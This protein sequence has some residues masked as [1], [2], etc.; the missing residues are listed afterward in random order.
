MAKQQKRD[1]KVKKTGFAGKNNSR[2]KRGFKIGGMIVGAAAAALLT[3][4]CSGIKNYFNDENNN[5][6]NGRNEVTPVVQPVQTPENPRERLEGLDD[7]LERYYTGN[8]NINATLVAQRGNEYIERDFTGLTLRDIQRKIHYLE[9]T[10]SF[11]NTGNPTFTEVLD[12]NIRNLTIQTNLGVV[13]I[14][15]PIYR[16]NEASSNIYLDFSKFLETVTNEQGS[17]LRTNVSEYTDENNFP[18]GFRVAADLEENVHNYLESHQINDRVVSEDYFQSRLVSNQRHGHRNYIFS[19]D[20]SNVIIAS[21]PQDMARALENYKTLIGEDNYLVEI[22][23]SSSREGRRGDLS[24]VV[25]EEPVYV[26]P[27]A[28]IPPITPPPVTPPTEPPY[29]PP[30]PPPIEEREGY[31]FSD[32]ADRG[33]GDLRDSNP[34][35]TQYTRPQR[36]PRDLIDSH[37]ETEPS[38]TPVESGDASYTR[39]A[40]GRDR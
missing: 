6:I 19:P 29:V 16:D 7:I 2:S 35:D 38:Y 24:D 22:V 25:D 33:A 34:S 12:S 9:D 37:R 23:D 21:I 10:A 17:I 20:G 11:Y 14:F 31:R 32:D 8:G 39:P 18:K 4:Q 5:I 28:P 1:G 40:I 36:A 30:S 15:N 26:P 13:D 27:V 3:Y